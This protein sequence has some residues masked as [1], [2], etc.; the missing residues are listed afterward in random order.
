MQV[1]LDLNSKLFSNAPYVKFAPEKAIRN[2]HIVLKGYLKLN[3]ENKKIAEFLFSR[4][5]GDLFQKVRNE[6]F[7]MK[8]NY[9]FSTLRI[10]K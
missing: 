6:Y 3:E 4:K 7:S 9:Q 8:A 2:D 5:G 1:L 10:V